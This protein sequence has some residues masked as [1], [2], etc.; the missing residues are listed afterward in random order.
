MNVSKTCILSSGG[1][2]HSYKQLMGNVE[3]SDEDGIL[4]IIALYEQAKELRKNRTQ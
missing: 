1:K 3:S 2:L 4:L